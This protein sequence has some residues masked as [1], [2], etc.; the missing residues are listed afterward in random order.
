MRGG[1]I[2]RGWPGGDEGSGGLGMAGIFE[3]CVLSF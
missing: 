2:K 1:F 3:K